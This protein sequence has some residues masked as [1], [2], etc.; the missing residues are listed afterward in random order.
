MKFKELTVNVCQKANIGNFESKGYGLTATVS[1]DEKDDL[2]AVKEQV[3]KKLEQFLKF[4]IDKLKGV[5][6]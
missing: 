5:K 3:T 4:E 6:Q 2:L 1:L